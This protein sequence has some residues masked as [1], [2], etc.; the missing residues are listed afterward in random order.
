L[1]VVSGNGTITLGQEAHPLRP[2][3][4][5]VIPAGVPHSLEA[6]SGQE[7]E[8]VIFG[9]PPMAMDDERARPVRG[10]GGRHRILTPRSDVCTP[11]NSRRDTLATR[12]RD[13]MYIVSGAFGQNLRWL[14]IEKAV[15]EF[16]RK[17]FFS[18]MRPAK[19]GENGEK[20][21]ER[22]SKQRNDYRL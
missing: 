21:I 11:K 10:V 18:A 22:N 17:C 3:S 15:C 14:E 5:A 2:G 7:L 9:T 20:Q 1:A 19:V 12:Q 4:L 16:T 13:N 8:F 6:D